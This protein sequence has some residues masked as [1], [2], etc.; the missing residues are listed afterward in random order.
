MSLKQGILTSV[1]N[2][3][4]CLNVQEL[5]GA[6]VKMNAAGMPYVHTGGYNMVFQLQ[7]N[8]KKWAFRVWHVSI[9]E[10]K[11]HA[12][13][14]AEY[15]N[16]NRL[17]YFAEFVYEDRAL[18]VEGE[19]LDAIR[20][21]WPDGYM[22]K[23]YLNKHIDSP[24]KII[25]IA[26][27]FSVMCELLRSKNISH[28]DLQH[29][30]IIV[31]AHDNIRLIDYDSLCIPEFEGRQEN[32][33]G[34]KGYQH[35]S[36]FTNG[37]MSIYSDYFSELIIYLSLIALSEDSSLWVK[38]N[39]FDSERLLF[40]QDDFQDICNSPIYIDL[41]K[42]SPKVTD[43]LHILKAYLNED[44]YLKLKPFGFYLVDP[45]I[46][47]FNV[48]PSILIPG[49][50]PTATWK[51]AHA[52]EV[53]LQNEVVLDEGETSVAIDSSKIIS[54]VAKG[55]KKTIRESI[56][57]SLCPTPTIK[58]MELPTLSFLIHAD[59]HVPTLDIPLS[60]MSFKQDI[61][62]KSDTESDFPELNSKVPLFNLNYPKRKQTPKQKINIKS[63]LNSFIKDNI[64]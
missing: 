10:S 29:G 14:I 12:M 5:M 51:V 41:L 4:V 39:V 20:M 27:R 37:K 48:T 30:N 52:L 23:D 53:K 11:E 26:E 50:K 24:E 42:L 33:F 58:I 13:K 61:G 44:D 43:L 49:V 17:E 63:F 15:L 34:L 22:L 57:V 35:P 47:F 32:I 64:D 16:K 1:S 46:V 19:Y 28:G 60:E 62:L 55:F 6:A 54:L 9:P 18:L 36:R 38:Y 56:N 31:D 7:H 59:I 21:R 25:M 3:E 45:E 40:D 8:K 2:L